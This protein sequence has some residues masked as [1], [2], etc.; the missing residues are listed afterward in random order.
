M[1]ILRLGIFLVLVSAGFVFAQSWTVD[2]FTHESVTVVEL[3][4]TSLTAAT[5]KPSGNVPPTKRAVITVED[6]HVRWRT[7]GTAPTQTVGH[8]TQIDGVII[9]ETL[10]DIINFRAFG[11]SST[12]STLHITYER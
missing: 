12:S 7:D 5:Y 4:S 2:S 9:L 10:S 8:L 3:T 1:K 6:A 11:L